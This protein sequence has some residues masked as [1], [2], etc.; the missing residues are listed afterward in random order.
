MRCSATSPRHRAGAPAEA[1]LALA[2]EALAARE[3]VL[4]GYEAEPCPWCGARKMIRSRSFGHCDG[5]D[6]GWTR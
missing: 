4:A 3:A 1:D 2:L 5:C 6:R